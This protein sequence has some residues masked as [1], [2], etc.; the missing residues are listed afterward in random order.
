VLTPVSLPANDGGL[1]YGQAVVAA[2]FLR[3]HLSSS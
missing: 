3:H 2:A 1:S